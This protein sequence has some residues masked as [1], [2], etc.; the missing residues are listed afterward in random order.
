MIDAPCNGG[1][2]IFVYHLSKRLRSNHS[3]R[4]CVQSADDNIGGLVFMEEGD[5]ALCTIRSTT[6][7]D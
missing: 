4:N 3:C 1:Q 6:I 2:E 5:Q 7:K